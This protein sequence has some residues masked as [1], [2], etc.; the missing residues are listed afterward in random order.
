ME[1]SAAM[2][3]CWRKSSYSNGGEANCVEAAHV[4]DTIL[5]RD[6]QD[7][8]AGPVLRVSAQAWRR[9]TSGLRA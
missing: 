5:V 4:L 9:F 3:P 8:G 2:N 6:T 7:R 1:E